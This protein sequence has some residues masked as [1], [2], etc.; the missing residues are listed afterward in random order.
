V[1]EVRQG[2]AAR[3]DLSDRR[4]LA[5]LGVF[6]F[7]AGIVVGAKLMKGAATSVGNVRAIADGQGQPVYGPGPSQHMHPA[8]QP[9][10]GCREREIQQ[11]RQIAA[12]AA[13]E[14][15]RRAAANAQGPTEADVDA[16]ERAAA[17]NRQLDG[18]DGLRT[19]S[20]YAESTLDESLV[21]QGDSSV[22][23]G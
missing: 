15:A 13:A 23:E 18:V 8:D 21:T 6:L 4:N 19:F 1:A 10:A 3:F 11:G 9:C 17:G 2:I 12:Q 7:C 20:A 5:G 16:A 22:P 14:A